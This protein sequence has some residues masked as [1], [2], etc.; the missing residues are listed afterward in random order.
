MDGARNEPQRIAE[1][2]V[3]V[4]VADGRC[5]SDE[6]SNKIGKKGGKING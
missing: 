6:Q 4:H 2:G 5:R 1:C 3:H